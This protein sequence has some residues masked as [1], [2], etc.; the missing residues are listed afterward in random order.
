MGA[1][2]RFALRVG[3][4]G[5]I[6]VLSYAGDAGLSGGVALE[7]HDLHYAIATKNG[8]K[9]KHIL[10][11][12]HGRATPGQLVAIMGPTGPPC[13]ETLLLFSLRPSVQHIDPWL[14]KQCGTA[15][16]STLSTSHW[17]PTC[18]VW[19]NLSTKRTRCA[20]NGVQR[21]HSSGIGVGEGPAAKRWRIS[22]HVGVCAAR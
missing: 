11:G 21:G 14:L 15:R 4:L 8:G 22:A 17:T 5:A 13:I 3:L 10:S 20:D 2:L 1:M 12:L 7:W 16:D 9:L 18:R 6:F 19:Q